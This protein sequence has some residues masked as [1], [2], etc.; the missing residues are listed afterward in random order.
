[1][2]LQNFR[3]L[4]CRIAPGLTSLLDLHVA[5]TVVKNNRDM[6]ASIQCGLVF[7]KTPVPATKFASTATW[8][9]RDV[10]QLDYDFEG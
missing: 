5:I 9:V 4:S 6:P 2:I 3:E 1:M 7:C 8:M 10:E